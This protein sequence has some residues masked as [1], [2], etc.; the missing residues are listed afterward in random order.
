MCGTS[1]R[2]ENHTTPLGKF[3]RFFAEIDGISSHNIIGNL[4]AFSTALQISL[5]HDYWVINS[6]AT[7]HMTCQMSYLH[8][9]KKL[10]KPSLFSIVNGKGASILEKRKIKLISK[11]FESI[12]L[13]VPCFSCYLSSVGRNTNSLNCI[14]MFSPRDVIFEDL[15]T[16]KKIGD[17]FNLNGFYYLSKDS[18]ISKSSQVISNSTQDQHL[19]HQRLAHPL[20][21]VSS[22]FPIFC[23]NL[24]YLGYMPLVEVY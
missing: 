6:S 10:S 3:T 21:P 11:T 23:K 16:G 1:S 13:Y 14:A 5:V 24:R 8:D 7:D 18:Q 20:D 22:K 12:A 17:D 9:A 4:D 2:P 15:I 19:L